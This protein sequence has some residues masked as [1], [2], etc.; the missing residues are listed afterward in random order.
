MLLRNFFYYKTF[1]TRFKVINFFT[2]FWFFGYILKEISQEHL[3][4]K[5]GDGKVDVLSTP[6]LVCLLELACLDCIK[7][8]P[9]P[10]GEITVGTGINVKHMHPSPA[11]IKLRCDAILKTVEDKKLVF[12]VSAQDDFEKVAEGTIE[13]VIVNEEHFMSRAASKKTR[14]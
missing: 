7:D 13:R 14:T 11:G 5:C 4:S 9:L 6:T 3:A 2:L 1:A 8:I 10:Q 12:E